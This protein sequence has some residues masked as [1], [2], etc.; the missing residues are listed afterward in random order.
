MTPADRVA[1]RAFPKADRRR[2]F[3]R[4]PRHLSLRLAW[5]ATPLLVSLPMRDPARRFGRLHNL[6]R[7]R[8]DVGEL[9]STMKAGRHGAG[10]WVTVNSPPALGI[11]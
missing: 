11:H 8:G 4:R 9:R 6:F 2:Y 7:L 1:E 10:L 3:L 5:A